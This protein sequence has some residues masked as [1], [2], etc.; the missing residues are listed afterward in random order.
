VNLL[1]EKSAALAV[2]LSTRLK[3]K[4]VVVKLQEKSKMVV[5]LNIIH[6]IS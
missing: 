3:A 1:R 2:T 6:S 5:N 4:V